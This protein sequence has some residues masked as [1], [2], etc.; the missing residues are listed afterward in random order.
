MKPIQ[1]R[2]RGFGPYL[3]EQVIRFDELAEYGLFLICG[4][5]GS[6]KTAILD[7]MCC[8]LYGSCSGEIRGDLEAMR[9]KQAAPEEPTE[10]EFVFESG[11]KRYCFGRKLT[12]RKSR[13]ADTPASF[14]EDYTCRVM[15]DGEWI[16]LLDNAKKRSMNAKAEELIGLNPDQFRQVIILPQGKFETL[17]TSGSEDKENILSSLFHTER[18]KTAVERMAAEV[19]ERRDDIARETQRIR[20]GLARLGLDTADALPEALRGAE[21]AA[22]EAAGKERRAAEEKEAAQAVLQVKNDFAELDARAAKLAAAQAAAEGDRALRV[23]LEMAVKAEKASGP[24]RE[25]EWAA[26]SF[27]MAEKAL[28]ETRKRL[29][30]AEE[31][32]RQAEA[33]RAALEAAAPEQQKRKEE[34][35]RL[36]ALRERYLNLRQLREAA[37]AAKAALEAAK[38]KEAKARAAN[39]KEKEKLDRLMAGWNEANDA[40]ARIMNEYHAAAAGRLAA[41][42]RDGAACPVCGSVHHPFPAALPEGAP[43]A[44]DVDRAEAEMNRAKDAYRAGDQRRE[45]AETVLREAQSAMMAAAQAE[46]AATGSLRQAEEQLDPGLKTLGDLDSRAARLDREIRAWDAEKERLEGARSQALVDRDALKEAEK[47]RAMQRESAQRERDE[48][49]AAWRKALEETGFETEA[50]FAAAEMTPEAQQALRDALSAHEAQLKGA[51]EALS[52]QQ[53]KTEGKERPDPRAAEEAFREAEKAVTEA[54][55]AATLARQNLEQLK[56]EA[57][58]LTALDAKTAKRRAALEADAAFVNALRGSVGMSIQRYVLSVRLGQVIAEANRLL[59]GIYGGRYRL[60]RSN[61]SYGTA[62]KSGLELEVY[63]SLN[64]RNRSVCTLSGGEK[65]LA[66]L[67]LAIGLCTVVQNEQRGVNLEA[68]FIDEGFG[69]LDRNSLGDALD[70]LQ[71]VQRGRGLVG[72]ISHVALLEET[73]PAKIEVRK[74]ARGSSIVN[75]EFRMQNA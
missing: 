48:K 65:F 69:T 63:D 31:V 46:A 19:K 57:A 12:P 35:A 68:M 8:A 44:R 22:E 54:I 55:R 27:E 67:A 6:G 71:G 33:D 15:E 72:I 42:L 74:T 51:R 73:I 29:R 11:G 9:C 2:F 70:V 34:L 41:G 45:Q 3:D 60:R 59:S 38:E 66:A 36:G 4:E 5:T 64:D 21:A 40:Y 26:G 18:W 49:E 62:H 20:D 10:V 25:R 1:V 14:N 30:Q 50:Q 56:K 13:R 43:A 37:D 75:S 39:G 7:A 52:E 28:E 58:E 24:R 16:P 53:A 61:E 32:L 23:R 47:D 17:L